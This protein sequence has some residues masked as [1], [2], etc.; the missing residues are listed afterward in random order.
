[1]R[2]RRGTGGALV[3]SVRESGRCISWV[4]K[5]FGDFSEDLCSDSR[6]M[7]DSH[8]VTG[9]H[10]VLLKIPSSHCLRMFSQSFCLVLRIKWCS[11]CQDFN[12]ESGPLYTLRKCWLLSATSLLLW[13]RVLPIRD[14]RAP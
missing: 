1:M 10:D 3:M 6:E 8:K 2:E 5:S 14:W 7:R 12:T 4:V 11:T 9:P 13:L